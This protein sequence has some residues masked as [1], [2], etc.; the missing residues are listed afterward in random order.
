VH[1]FRAI[2]SPDDAIDVDIVP[3]I[4]TP[5]VAAHAPAREPSN[6]RRPT[7]DANENFIDRYPTCRRPN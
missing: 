6:G 4:G 1:H 3:M 5:I 7:I 2:F